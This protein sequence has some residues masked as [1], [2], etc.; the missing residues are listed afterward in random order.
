MKKRLSNKTSK[1]SPLTTLFVCLMSLCFLLTTLPVFSQTQTLSKQQYRDKTLAMIL[2]SIGGALTGYEYLNVYNTPNG[3]YQPG[4]TQKVPKE[5]LLGMP[6]SWLILLNGTLGGTTKD[7]HNY[8]S[9]FTEGKMNSDDDQHIDFFN[10][11]L[12]NKYGPG[13]SYQDIKNEWMEKQVSDFGGGQGAIEVMRDK[14]LMAPQCGHRD[15]GNS[16]HWLPECYIEHEMM[17]AA[18]PGMPNKSVEFTE[19]FSSITGEGENVQW[20]YYWAAAHSVAFFETDIRTTVV[21]ALGML[22]ATAVQDRCTTFVLVF[23][24][25]IQPTGVPRYVSFGKTTGVL[26]LP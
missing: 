16:G 10:Q 6:D 4:A 14:N 20:G 23:I 21:K 15:H 26:P 25:N 17:G 18:F 2:G 3:Y 11:F 22:P 24:K 13:I 5:P 7:E 19:R 9:W 12:L 8:G 1:S